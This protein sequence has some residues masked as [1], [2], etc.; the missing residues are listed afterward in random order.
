MIP[1]AG[2]EQS[3][4]LVNRL[5]RW[6][7]GRRGAEESLPTLPR[8]RFRVVCIS[9]E[10][11]SGGS[12]IGKMVA[13]RLGWRFWDRELLLAIADRMGI[14][15]EQA[16]AL[17]ELPP[18][19]VQAWA[20]PLWEEHYAP[21]ETYL[22]HLGKLIDAIG[23]AGQSVVIGR[24]AGFAL[25]RMEVLSVRIVA[26]LPARANR[27][28]ERMG[29]SA[30]TARR[31]AQDLDRRR[32]RFAHLQLGVD[33][34]AVASYDLVLDSN[35]LGERIATEV[36]VRAV[37]CGQPEVELMPAEPPPALPGTA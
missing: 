22:D 15:E 17:D 35:S 19:R 1:S 31:M 2:R 20:L 28:A 32:N 30:R 34:R 12:T 18:T 9:R 37:E 7:L 21:H 8:A 6:W 5:R 10:A 27:L 3:E 33:A 23:R 25:P 36:I 29:V 24:G 26:P 4:A 14:T 11:G 16:V 13:E